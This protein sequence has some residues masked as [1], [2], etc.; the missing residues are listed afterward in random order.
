MENHLKTTYEVIDN[1]EIIKTMK[2]SHVSEDYRKQRIAEIIEDASTSEKE[3]EIERLNKLNAYLKTESD[4]IEQENQKI[5]RAYDEE[6]NKFQA[7]VNKLNDAL[8]HEVEARN[9]LKKEKQDLLNELGHGFHEKDELAKEKEKVLKI[10][11]QKDED[12]EEIKKDFES[13]KKAYIEIE[14]AYASSKKEEESLMKILSQSQESEK[15]LQNQLQD[16]KDKLK[17]SEEKLFQVGKDR[18]SLLKDKEEL[19]GKSEYISVQVKQLIEDEQKTSVQIIEEMKE[20]F[21]GKI[22]EQ[23]AQIKELATIN[24]TLAKEGAELREELDEN[25]LNCEKIIALMKNDMRVI[26]NE[27]EKRCQEIELG[28]EKTIVN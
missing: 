19:V 12:I 14:E 7:A 20:K 23:M 9:L 18:D 5:R 25:K 4:L 21:R 26:K 24:E 8:H 3:T 22:E 28:S 1:D 6:T 16:L 15:A 17:E 2:L 13:I 11:R 10:L 27:W